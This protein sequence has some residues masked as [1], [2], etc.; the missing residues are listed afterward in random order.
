MAC[1]AP[2]AW[3]ICSCWVRSFNLS[4]AD[5]VAVMEVGKVRQVAPP[6]ELYEYPGS[7]FVA[8]FIGKM[9]LFEGRVMAFRDGILEVDISGLGR[10]EVPHQGE[11]SGDIGVAIRPEKLRLS[12]E[13]PVQPCISFPAVLD[14]VAYHGSE[15]HM[16][17]T[18]GSGAQLTATI[19]NDSRTKAR[20]KAGE[21]MW[22]SWIPGD[23]LILV[24]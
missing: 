4:M 10:F 18:T 12:V 11:V 2:S 1:L 9:N 16:F 15:S 3:G 5:R 6:G 24:E 13:R 14:N 19:Q 22:G 17:Y 23:T 21:R 7:R 20:V 8:D